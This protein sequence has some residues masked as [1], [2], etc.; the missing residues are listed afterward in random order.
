M[1]FDVWGCVRVKFIVPTYSLNSIGVLSGIITSISHGFSSVGL[2]LFAG[3]LINKTYSRYLDS[4]FFI[5]SIFRGLLLF[6]LLANLSFPGSFNFS[7]FLVCL[8]LVYEELDYM[9]LVL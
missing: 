5:D 4:F 9:K 8:F 3:L 7:L 6:F 1:K 2:F